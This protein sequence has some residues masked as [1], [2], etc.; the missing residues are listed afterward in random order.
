MVV[1]GADQLQVS[2][3]LNVSTIEAIEEKCGLSGLSRD[4]LDYLS[5]R[6]VDMV[7]N[8]NG[9]DEIRVLSEGQ[10]VAEEGLMMYRYLRLVFDGVDLFDRADGTAPSAWMRVDVYVKGAADS[11]PFTSLAVYENNAEYNLFKDYALSRKERPQ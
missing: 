11:E 5:F 9:E 1:D 10:V 6:L 7:T 2:L 4:H 3:R 8:E